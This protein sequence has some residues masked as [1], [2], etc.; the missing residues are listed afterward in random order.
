M[1]SWC[2][3]LVSALQKPTVN[4]K[5][6]VKYFISLAASKVSIC[7][8]VTTLCVLLMHLNSLNIRKF[9]KGGRL[10]EHLGVLLAKKKRKKKGCSLLQIFTLQGLSIGAR[11]VREEKCRANALKVLKSSSH[12]VV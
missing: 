4:S 6:R 10:S 8:S 1:P 11:D 5:F 7:S 2:T 12:S 9:R 3:T